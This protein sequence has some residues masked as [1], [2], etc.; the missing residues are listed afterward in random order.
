MN[1][2][3]TQEQLVDGLNKTLDEQYQRDRNSIFDPKFDVQNIK[4]HFQE[5][6]NSYT[7][8]RKEAQNNYIPALKE[9]IVFGDDKWSARER[10]LNQKKQLYS[11]LCAYEAK[12]THDEAVAQLEQAINEINTPFRVDEESFKRAYTQYEQDKINEIVNRQVGINQRKANLFKK[13]RARFVGLYVPGLVILFPSV[14]GAVWFWRLA[15]IS[16]R[17]YASLGYPFFE[18][19]RISTEFRMQF[20]FALMFVFYV[21]LGIG[22]A[23]PNRIYAR[24][25]KKYMKALK[26]LTP[27]IKED[28]NNA[29]RGLIQEYNDK[30]ASLFNES[31]SYRKAANDTL[32][33]CLGVF[34]KY[35]EDGS[36]I[37]ENYSFCANMQYGQ[38]YCL[39]DYMEKGVVDSYTGALQYYNNE[40]QKEMERQ[41]TEE[42]RKQMVNMNKEHFSKMESAAQDQAYAAAQQ[43]EAARRQAQAASDAAY[44]ARVQAEEARKQ[45]N[46][47]KKQTNIIKKW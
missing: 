40:V 35:N 44:Y 25:R 32:V 16:A 20:A 26:V 6:L 7:R 29:S 10:F 15:I 28:L 47:A 22:M 2:P 39:Y 45:T 24:K 9:D 37:Q 46:E 31:A 41:A 1:K 42:Y 43:A 3:Y 4:D 8:S 18:A 21:M 27:M 14:F 19:L 11:A 38:V 33:G 30:Y 12:N 34:K 36:S 17:A 23:I 5:L 13:K